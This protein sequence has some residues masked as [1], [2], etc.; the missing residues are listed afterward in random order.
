MKVSLNWVRELN[1][2]YKCAAEPAPEGI[3]KLVE[4]I[5]SQLGAVEEVIDLGERYKGIVIVKVVSVQKHPNADKLTVCLID[6]GKTVKN[7]KRDKDNLVQIVCGAPNVKAGMLAVW[8]PPGTVLP[9]SYDKDPLVI[10]AREIRGIASNGMLASHRELALG[11]QHEGIVEVDPENMMVDSQEGEV[12]HSEALSKYKSVPT[13]RPGQDFAKLYGLDDYIIDIENKMFTHRPDCFGILGVAR[14]IAGIQ[15][16]VFVSPPVYKAP[17]TTGKLFKQILPLEI[18]NEVPQLVPRFIAQ[19]F[20]NVEVRPSDFWMQTYLARLGVKPINNIV[21]I[22]NY[23][24]L[25]T[26]QP[27]HAYDYDKVCDLVEP[28]AKSQ[29]PKAA[30][31]GVRLSKKG[32][33]IKLLGGKEIT[34]DDGAVVITNGEKPIGLGGVMGG[35]DTEVDESSKNIII[36]CANFDMTATRNT[37]M[38]YWLFTEAAVRFTKGQS[39][40]QNDRVIAWIEGEIIHQA[41]GVPD[42]NIHDIRGNLPKNPTVR[43]TTEFINSRLGTDLP[44]NEMKK[45]LTNVEFEVSAEGKDLSVKAPFWRTDIE[46]PEDVAEEVGR[47]YGYE[48]LRQELPMRTLAPAPKDPALEFKSRLRNLMVKAG[49]NEV[50]TYSF[51]NKRLLEA[52]AQDPAEAYHI[53]N[54]LSPD[55]QYYRL[56]L[57]PSL[58]DK[59]HMNVKNGYDLFSLFEIGKSHVKDFLD[60]DKLPAEME[61]L[62]AVMIDPYAKGAP[63][64]QARHLVD[65]VLQNLNIDKRLYQPLEQAKKLK[66]SSVFNH[67]EPARSALIWS[68]DKTLG[69]VGEPSAGLRSVLKLPKGVSMFELDIPTLYDHQQPKTYHPLNKYPSSSQDICLRVAADLSYGEI[70]RFMWGELDKLAKRKDYNYV[71]E[72]VDIFQRPND[73]QHKQITWEITL[74]HPERTLTTEEFNILLDKIAE[75]AS[76]ELKAERV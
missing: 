7:V 64:Y 66:Q 49:A 12:K 13:V 6:D 24:M 71:M 19:V 5:G 59:V 73:K 22:T 76:K 9:E 56:S 40:W 63:Y 54:A 4:R 65:Y 33:K 18:K 70:D 44:A 48:H 21:D 32:E 47:L 23:F 41:G 74:S 57:A 69:I 72:T 46:I 16:H 62:A 53:R 2:Q 17:K 52:A 60:E 43:L 51:V 42:L 31:L 68:N 14:E 1:R 27:L 50:L 8:I 28:K 58:L 36:E 67:Y 30:T 55:L 26:G 37:A 39:P 34:L 11:E 45:L 38:A 25:L 15:H 20:A 61:T 3:D 29:K 10:E 75:V 35:A